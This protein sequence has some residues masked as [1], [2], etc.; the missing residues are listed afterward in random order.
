MDKELIHYIVTYNTHLLTEKEK[1]GV[2]HLHS[3]IKIGNCD[4]EDTRMKI[5]HKTD[6]YK[7]IGWM[8]EDKEILELIKGGQEELYK[9]IAERILKDHR[10]KIDFNNCPSCGQL[11][12]TPLARQCRHCGHSW[13]Y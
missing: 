6:L 7:R 9:K 3:E 11:A 10:G 13:R 4:G 1:L 8:T 12:R 5:E 2:K